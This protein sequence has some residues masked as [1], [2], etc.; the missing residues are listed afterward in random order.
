M[1]IP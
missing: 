1:W